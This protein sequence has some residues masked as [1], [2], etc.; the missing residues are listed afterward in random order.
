MSNVIA[1]PG[2]QFNEIDLSFSTRT[3]NFNSVYIT[4]FAFQGP[5]YEPTY[6]TSLPEYEQTFG[7]PTNAAERYMYHSARQ[8][9]TKT[10]SQLLVTRLPYDITAIVEDETKRVLSRSVLL[11]PLS[12][13]VV[14]AA[15]GRF[16]IGASN[17]YTLLEPVSIVVEESVYSR[18]VQ[19]GLD[20]PNMVV[21]CQ[22]RGLPTNDALSAAPIGLVISNDA[23]TAVNNLFEGMYIG[24]ADNS[25]VDPSVGFNS[26]TGIKAISTFPAV[27]INIS[28]PSLVPVGL[29]SV[30]SYNTWQVVDQKRLSF[31]VSLPSMSTGS[32]DTISEI[33]LKFPKG[34]QFDTPEFNDSLV[35]TLFNL[36]KSIYETTNVQLADIL[37]EGE[38]GSV[39]VNKTR[40]GPEGGA[41]KSVY[42]ESIVNG[43]SPYISI[44]INPTLS[45]QDW[46][47]TTTAIVSSKKKIRV[48][49]NT[50]NLYALG[51][52]NTINSNDLKQLGDLPSK[53]QTAI[54]LIDSA[55]NYPIDITCDAGLSTIWTSI[56]CKNDLTPPVPV[57]T[58]YKDE[59]LLGVGLAGNP[60]LDDLFNKTGGVGKAAIVSAHNAILAIFESF[61]TTRRDHIHISDPLRQIFIEGPNFKRID[62]MP[63]DVGLN[64]NFYNEMYWPLYH[65]YEAH[66][67]SY[68]ATYPNWFAVADATLKRNLWIPPSG[69]VA[70]C[71]INSSPVEAPAGFTRGVITGV[72]D[73]AIS[74]SQK[75]RDQLYK[76]SQNPISVFPGEGTVIFGQKTLLNKPSAFDRLNVRRTFIYLEKSTNAVLKYFVFEPNTFLI[77]N[78]ITNTLRPIFEQT[79]NAG[80]IYDYRIVCDERNNTPNTIDANELHVDIYVKPT[81]TAEFILVNFYATRT[82]QNFSEL[83]GNV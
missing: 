62:R 53:V 15:T 37:L 20:W 47:D 42:L 32:K 73:S 29:T 81:R 1:S 55:D 33:V 30:Y 16:D 61:A 82:D 80:G 48:H 4:G 21:D 25:S 43:P 51:T 39:N 36:K 70:A 2:V 67:T 31:N 79:K 69:V 35:I 64:F 75:Q 22:S 17:D 38:M 7:V 27:D 23:S 71:I 9:L 60:K 54:S 6:V 12:A 5:I 83:I 76:I 50:K 45:H 59:E 41:P 65:L 14:D 57:D 66:A 19:H 3:T 34:Y 77:R 11:Y 58:S 52:Y 26:I 18:I 10:N 28:A 8:I 68:V 74:P 44:F 56:R 63:S 13:D 49:N 40:V 24:I 46:E 72:A 78:R